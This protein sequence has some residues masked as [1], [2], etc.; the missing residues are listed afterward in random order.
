MCVTPAAQQA[1]NQQ[2][3]FHR[4]IPVTDWMCLAAS[5]IV[6]LQAQVSRSL[7]SC[8]GALL[9]V[10]ASQGVEAQTLANVWLALEND[11][12]IVP[13][14]NKIDL[15]GRKFKTLGVQF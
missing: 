3:R 8:E 4:N 11:L 15:P 13:V 12:E 6:S 14:L 10:D 9:V 2:C 5:A 1:N 7:S